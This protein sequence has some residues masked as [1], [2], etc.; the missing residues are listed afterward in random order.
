MRAKSS[1]EIRDSR[2]TNISLAGCAARIPY[3]F[4]RADFAE[5]LGSRF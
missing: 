4:G 1:T 2:R 5:F 3:G